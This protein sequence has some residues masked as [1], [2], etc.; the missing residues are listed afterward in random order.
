MRTGVI[1]MGSC[2]LAVTSTVASA[3]CQDGD[4]RACH[5]PDG[6]I[7]LVAC[8]HGKWPSCPGTQPAPLL[9][10]DAHDTPTILA[11]ADAFYARWFGNSDDQEAAAIDTEFTDSSIPFLW[12][13]GEELAALVQMYDLV[14]P[15][16]A[17]RA[18]R[19]L[20]RLRRM[21]SEM[22]A[23]RDDRREL[24]ITHQPPVDFFRKKSMAAWGYV[25]HNRDD[26]WNTDVVTSGLFAYAMAAFA[27]RVT[28][29]P[30]LQTR[31]PF[32][33]EEAIRLL[34]AA[35]DTYADFLPEQYLRAADPHAY[36]T[37]PKSYAALTCDND[38]AGCDGYRKTAG[39]PLAYNENLS[40][41]K[42]LAEMA[43]AADSPLYRSSPDATPYRMYLATTLAPQVIAK[44]VEY[45]RSAIRI[46]SYDGVPIATWNH[47]EPLPRIQDTGHA[48]FELG[49]LAV[50]V[51]GQNRLNSILQ[52][53][54]Q[55]DR[56]R[57]DSR[58]FAPIVNT[59]LRV[60]WKY[61]YQHPNG[62][63]NVI[64]KNVD[65]SDDN[66][67]DE[68][69]ANAAC[70]GW[71]TLA[72]FNPWMWV[73]CRDSVL[74]PAPYPNPDYLTPGSHAALLRYRQPLQPSHPTHGQIKHPDSHLNKPTV[75]VDNPSH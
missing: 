37:V 18:D 45:F 3:A 72:P 33:R 62:P 19:Y 70:G 34:N 41:M 29:D 38:A 63:R 52:Q 35:V 46:G 26:H 56:I 17:G 23:F 51:D 7:G 20:E 61:D 5:R 59:F 65:G 73:R 54:Q 67:S 47:Q 27:R 64:K 24:S 8:N 44:N 1:L 4:T 15:L 58:F 2:L 43:L 12:Y 74:R 13:H 49:S 75:H 55:S 68:D 14:A 60:L 69:N 66:A 40:L 31:H 9:I 10:G 42:A 28:D 50:I 36:F 53:H 39:Q 48:G 22:L 30:A 6:S 32:Y 71:V 21:A 57:L 11:D 25:T 16:D